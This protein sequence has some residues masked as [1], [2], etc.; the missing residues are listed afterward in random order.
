M[1]REHEENGRDYF[2]MTKAQVRVGLEHELGSGLRA[3]GAQLR[4]DVRGIVQV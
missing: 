3:C 2:F 4:E 1:P